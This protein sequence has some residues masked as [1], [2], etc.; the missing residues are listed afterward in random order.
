MALISASVALCLFAYSWSQFEGYA[1]SKIDASVDHASKKI[2]APIIIGNVDIGL[3]SALFTDVRL[4]S[5]AQVVISSMRADLNINPFDASFGDIRSIAVADMRIK[6]TEKQVRA[7]LLGGGNTISD[8]S[9]RSQEAQRT[10]EKLF[11][12]LPSPELSMGS[13]GITLLDSDGEAALSVQG[14]KLSIERDASRVLVRLGELKTRSGI[15]ERDLLARFELSPSAKDYRF[16]LRRKDGSN[17]NK[18]AWGVTGILQKDLRNIQLTADMHSMPSFITPVFKDLPIGLKQLRGRVIL[19]LTRG[20]NLWQFNTQVQSQGSIVQLPLVSSQPLGPVYFDLKASGSYQPTSRLLTIDSGTVSLPNHENRE[21]GD[22]AARFALNGSWQME[23]PSLGGQVVNA[24]LSLPSTP[25]QTV[26]NAAPQGLLPALNGFRLSGDVAATLD[27]SMKTRSLGDAYVSLHDTLFNCKVD[28][29]PY[30]YSAERLNGP[31]SIRRQVTKNSPPIDIEVSPSSPT[32]AS[33]DKVSHNVNSTFVASEDAGFY[34]HK[35]VDINAIASA[36]RRD[37]SEQR[38]ALGGSTITMQTVKNLFLTPERTMSRKAQ[39]IFLAWHLE[40]ILSKDRILEIYV[41]IVELGPGIYGIT[42][43][44]QRFFGKS[45]D[46]L[47]LVEAAYLANLLPSPKIRYRYFCQGRVTAN[48]RE[49]VNGLLK[50]MVNLRHI[51]SE[52][53]VEALSAPIEFNEDARL[54]AP[55]CNVKTMGAASQIP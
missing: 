45:P 30:A 48:F 8:L 15:R 50:R 32:Y 12:S 6:T 7:P 9:D 19:E 35:G 17:R 11:A 54:G 38:I 52:R 46:G 55:D 22:R 24:H 18:N 36:L 2:G 31:F 29:A 34:L 33:L 10:I 4:G 43:A 3:G 42:T 28:E 23:P 16:F 13:V 44:S 53:F 21:Y 40:H 27:I 37:L 26:L 47:N 51:T 5:E 49:L 39:E 14:L 1:R 41:N 25:C 20:E